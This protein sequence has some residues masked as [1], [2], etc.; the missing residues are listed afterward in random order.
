MSFNSTLCDMITRIRNGQHARKLEIFSVKS[1]L[2]LSVL[3][4]LEK[5]GYIRG[6]I[7]REKSINILLKYIKDKPVITKIETILSNDKNSYL[8]VKSLG[9]FGKISHN[10][11]G[12]SLLILSTPKGVLTAYESILKNTGGRLL[13][14]VF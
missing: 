5:E 8:S 13:I 6:Y 10:N 9:K 1:K 12:L 3:K 4:V 2:C 11:K 7:E 14:K